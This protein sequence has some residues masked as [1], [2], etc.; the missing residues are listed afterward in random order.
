MFSFVQDSTMFML[1]VILVLSI[2]AIVFLL[3]R[4]KSPPIA[5]YPPSISL[6]KFMWLLFRSGLPLYELSRQLRSKYGAIYILNIF[7]RKI[8][9]LTDF[10][11]VKEAFSNSK[12]L[13]RPNFVETPCESINGEYTNLICFVVIDV[14]CLIC[15][16]GCVFVCLIFLMKWKGS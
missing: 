2:S 12:L 6:I 14:V 5:P 7:G 1:I 8:V 9:F 13:S 10:A 11:S 3:R 4:T 15:L 16:L